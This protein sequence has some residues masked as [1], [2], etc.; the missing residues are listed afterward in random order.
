MGGYASSEKVRGGFSSRCG[1]SL[2]F[3]PIHHDWIGVAMGA[4]DTPRETH[5]A[6]VRQNER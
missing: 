3:D 4:F 5:L 1:C 6:G 2:F